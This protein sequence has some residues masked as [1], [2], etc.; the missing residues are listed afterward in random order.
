[1]FPTLQLHIQLILLPLFSPLWERKKK[2]HLTN[3]LILWPW[4][5]GGFSG[6]GP[7]GTCFSYFIH[8]EVVKSLL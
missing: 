6:L 4:P 1:M 5:L 2:K 8:Q 7:R 3:E